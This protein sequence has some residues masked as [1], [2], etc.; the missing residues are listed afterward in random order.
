MLKNLK[1]GLKLGLGFGV[2]LCLTVIILI[3]G[4]YK[5]GQIDNKL[6]RIVNRNNVTVEN[7][8]AAAKAIVDISNSLRI[9][10]NA[11]A[12]IAQKERIDADRKIYE[13]AMIKVKAI[14][15]QQEGIQAIK[16]VEDAIV[17]ANAA[18]K[19]FL[20]LYNADNISEAGA[21]LIT[22]SLPLTQK[23]VEEFDKL[24]KYE[25]QRNKISYEE[26]K[27]A[28]GS[29]TLSMVIF[30]VAALI[31]GITISIIVT[32][33]LTVPLHNLIGKIEELASG[34][35]RVS[36]DNDRGD[37]IGSLSNSLGKMIQSLNKIINN[38]LVSANKVASTVEQLKT[39]S[40]KSAEGAKEQSGQ[41]AQI[42]TAAEEMS[43][44]ITDIARNASVSS[45]TTAEA[46]DVARGGQEVANNAVE[47]VNRVYTSTVELATMVEK[48]NSRSSEIGDIITVIKDIAD[49]TNLL[50]LNAAIEAA[51]A[52]EQGRGFA[53]V[54]DEVRKLAER[55]IK[56]TT[57]ISDKIGAVQEES[58]QTQES[59]SEAS[60]EVTKA[61]KYIRNVGDSL[62]SIVLAVQ[63]VRDQINQIATAVD[64]QSA[65]SEEVANN[66]EKTSHI[67]KEM[68]NTSNEVM[69]SVSGLL[70]I[71]EELRGAAGVFVTEGGHLIMCETARLDHRMFVAKISAHLKGTLNLDASKLPDNHTC[72][73]GKWYDT[74]GRE[75]CGN[76]PSYRTIQTPHERIHALAK[77][78]VSAYNAGD[79]EKAAKI[80][81]EIE[82][83]SKQITDLLENI[84]KESAG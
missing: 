19:K 27:Q 60:E 48:L 23:A 36:I 84:K 58:R 22:E 13:D 68:E 57:E 39:K 72:R 54:A 18:N 17:P 78:A 10:D 44:T 61:T 12:K 20:E 66:I 81:G 46:M 16:N 2:V 59:M 32:R 11:A 80:Y 38:I 21:V 82:V 49:Q 5:M 69:T 52:G 31:I 63:K 73:F 33:I 65:A 37:E 42:A 25:N 15:D 41:A 79:K 6:E 40:E 7:A 26:A 43:Q 24:I 51:R 14:E 50:A 74:I 34:N 28:Y 67:A 56:A 83:I 29:A 76:L 8:S 4:L 53:V 55:T 1:F 64:E 30:G 35:L 47:T 77:D 70:S 62:E 45:D 71:A 75:L 9:T 3:L